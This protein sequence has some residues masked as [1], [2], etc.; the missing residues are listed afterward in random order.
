MFRKFLAALILMFIVSS[1]CPVMAAQKQKKYTGPLLQDCSVY[2]LGG[3]E[4]ILKLQGRKLSEPAYEIDDNSIN[5]IFD[6][7]NAA[8]PE[9]INSSI[10]EFI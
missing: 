10:L 6:E 5:I 8:N 9:K 1:C 4:F 3:E 2:Q 7:T